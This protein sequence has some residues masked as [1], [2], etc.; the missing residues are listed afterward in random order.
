MQQRLKLIYNVRYSFRVNFILLYLSV[1]LLSLNSLPSYVRLKINQFLTSILYYGSQAIIEW[2]KMV[3][4][5][6]NEIML[7][8]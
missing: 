1:T 5:V 3:M 8:L 2:K 4:S 6:I 7:V